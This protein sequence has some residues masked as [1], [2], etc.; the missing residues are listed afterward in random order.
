MLAEVPASIGREFAIEVLAEVPL[1]VRICFA[2][3]SPEVPRLKPRWAC[4]G[5]LWNCRGAPGAI[6][7]SKW[8]A[9]P[10]FSLPPSDVEVV[11][12]AVAP[13]EPCEKGLLVVKAVSGR[14]DPSGSLDG[15]TT[16]KLVAGAPISFTRSDVDVVEGAVAPRKTFVEGDLGDLRAVKAE[17][18]RSVRV[19]DRRAVVEVRV[20]AVAPF[21]V[22]RSDL[23]L[24]G[25]TMDP[26]EA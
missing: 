9:G 14:A 6:A 24:V 5:C 12:G 7:P 17:S 16:L 1:F 13:R 20:V 15:I 25:G 2:D 21:S 3:V 23:G 19:I 10:P 11:E 22:V 26:T 18:L 4:C 8:V